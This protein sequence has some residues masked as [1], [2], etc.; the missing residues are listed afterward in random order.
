MK[1]ILVTGANGYIG[2]HIVQK[3]L[4]FVDIKIIATDLYIDKIDNPRVQTIN[5]NIFNI[6]DDHF[7]FFD[8]PDICLHIAWR[9]GFIHNSNSHMED[10]S[11]HYLFLRNLLDSGLK[12]L[13]IMGTMHEIGY[14]EGAIDE[15]TPC[16][17]L[18]MYGIAKNALRKSLQLLIKDKDVVFQWLRAFYIYGDDKRNK[19]IFSKI[20]TAAEEGKDTFP[21][22]NGK[23][24]Y[25]FIHIDELVKQI[26]SCITQTE[27]TGIINCCTG[28]PVSIG[29]KVEEF[30]RENKLNIKLIYGAFPD[31]E[32][33]SPGIWGDNKKIL[34]IIHK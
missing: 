24:L 14:Y 28:K 30:I 13:A 33:D 21:F 27:V 19:S 9:D 18:S 15:N 26:A 25:D 32:Y 3:L 10:L 31:R 2:R 20:L 8:K 34:K 6:K 17:P 7:S 4:D 16:N 5:T 11:N 22:T 23:I 12:Q 29:E 1:K